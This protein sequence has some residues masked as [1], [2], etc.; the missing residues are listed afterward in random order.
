VS[1][2]RYA[3]DTSVPID[4]TQAEVKDRLRKAGADQLAI[5]EGSGSS[6]VGFAL[7]GRMY[8]L[9]VPLSANPK[10]A[11]QDEK[12]AWRL[13]LLLLKAKLEA[14]TEGA[15]T[16]EREFLA[17]ML[18]PNGQTVY[19]R[20]APRFGDCLRNEGYAAVASAGGAARWISSTF[21]LA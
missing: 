6:M 1:G 7:A 8:R 5:Y 13:L 11:A 12:R 3:E 2:R 15:T 18:L 19:E 16:I 4:R 10:S 20:S 21:P 9:T 17:D 14:V